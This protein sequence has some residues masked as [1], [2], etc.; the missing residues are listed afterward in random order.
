M[1]NKSLMSLI[2][3]FGMVLVLSSCTSHVQ[4]TG[5]SYNNTSGGNN[6]NTAGSAGPTYY[7]GDAGPCGG[8]IFYDRG[9]YTTGLAQNWRYLEAAPSDFAGN[10]LQTIAP[11][12]IPDGGTYALSFDGG[13][14]FTGPINYNDDAITIN[15]AIL[16][17]VGSSDIV[18]TGELVDLSGN[19]SVITI[20]FAGA[21]ALAHQTLIVVDSSALSSGGNTPPTNP[22]TV[23]EIVKGGTPASVIWSDVNTL[24]GTTGTGI[25]TGQANTALVIAQSHNSAAYICSQQTTGNCSDWYLPSEGELYPLYT[26]LQAAGVSMALLTIDVRNLYLSSSEY[27]AGD[28]WML[29]LLYANVVNPTQHDH[30]L[31]GGLQ[32]YS[33]KQETHFVRCARR[34]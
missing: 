31:G 24:I 11:V 19:A 18:A 9:R 22:P 28:A 5:N 4:N 27:D 2:G 23:T 13:S 10:E 33:P 12:D 8:I 17:L 6:N 14:T 7:I 1:W 20:D 25:G 29:G 16:A 21:Y 15:A 30:F 32:G 3:I 26:N 34:F